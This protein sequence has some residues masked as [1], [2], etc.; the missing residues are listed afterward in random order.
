MEVPT[1][2]SM[3]STEIFEFVTGRNSLSGEKT[4]KNLVCI[5]PLLAAGIAWSQDTADRITV[6]FSDPS[7]PHTLKVHLINGGI[8]V[9]WYAGQDAA[10]ETPGRL[11]DEHRL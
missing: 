6:P 2:S 4:V 8:T 7:R 10:I 9:Q 3:P 5:L 1:S 11:D